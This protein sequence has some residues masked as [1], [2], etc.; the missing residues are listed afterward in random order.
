[1]SN[2]YGEITDDNNIFINFNLTNTEI[3]NLCS[4]SREMINRMLNDLR[5]QN[6][7]SIEKGYITI[8][9]LNYLKA[10]ICC[11]NCPIEICRID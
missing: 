11:D 5:K 7:L 10:E 6:I 9:D 2:T 8:H 1:M 4:T 3:A